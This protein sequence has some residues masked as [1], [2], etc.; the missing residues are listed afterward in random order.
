MGGYIALKKST[1]TNMEN[2]VKWI[3]FEQLNSRKQM[4]PYMGELLLVAFKDEEFP[5]GIVVID[6]WDGDYFRGGIGLWFHSKRG[7]F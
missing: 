3:K 6:Y 4:K 5:E 1:R 7:P 2:K